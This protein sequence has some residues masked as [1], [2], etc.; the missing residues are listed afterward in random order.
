[1]TGLASGGAFLG[2]NHNTTHHH[3]CRASSG[4]LVPVSLRECGLLLH[5]WQSESYLVIPQQSQNFRSLHTQPPSP[6]TQH[7]TLNTH[8]PPSPGTHPSHH[9]PNQR[10]SLLQPPNFPPCLP[11]HHRN[12][13]QNHPHHRFQ[14]QRHTHHRREA[15]LLGKLLRVVRLG[16]RQPSSAV[17][18]GARLVKVC[19]GHQHRPHAPL[20]C[21]ECRP[22]VAMRGLEAR[23]EK[24]GPAVGEGAVA[25]GSDF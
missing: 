24:H 2:F 14:A 11:K 10:K 22:V 20:G 17:G 9:H 15:S 13:Q 7:S 25:D 6:D 12:P 16:T 19:P 23:R 3:N 21:R 5:A 8:R 18:H 1:M 4:I